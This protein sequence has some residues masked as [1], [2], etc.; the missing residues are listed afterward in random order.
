MHILRGVLASI[1][2]ALTTVGVCCVL[3][4]WYVQ[5]ALTPVSRKGAIRQKMDR[6]ILWWTKS[7]RWMI[8]RLKLTEPQIHWQG[9][10]RLS[11]EQWYLVVC[12]H[13]TWADILLLQTYLL[14]DIPPLKFFTKSQLIWLPFIGLAMSALGFPYV[15]RVSKEQIKKNPALRNADKNN[16]LQACEGFKNHP[17][18]ILNFAEGTR[19]TAEKY[20]RQNGAL[21]HLLNPKPGGITYMLEGMGDQLDGLV[22]VTLVYPDGVPTFWDFLQGKCRRVIFDARHCPIPELAGKDSGDS[23]YKANV[24]RWVQSMWEE[25]DALITDYLAKDLKA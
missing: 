6:I 7:N 25:K 1:S 13:Q 22:N 23:S 21:K 16:V 5:F 14:D 17:T 11:P 24:A 4:I 20:Q 2:I 19:L 8:K 10:E 3:L 15:K 18:S 9:R 12:N